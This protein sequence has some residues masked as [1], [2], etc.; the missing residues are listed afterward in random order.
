MCIRINRIMSSVIFTCQHLSGPLT[1]WL[2]SFKKA[3]NTRGIKGRSQEGGAVSAQEGDR[4]GQ[5]VK[6]RANG[7]GGLRVRGRGQEEWEEPIGMGGCPKR[8]GVGREGGTEAK[9]EGARV[10]EEG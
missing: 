5:E 4:R 10:P 3:W 8:E 2:S 6:L 9:R 1:S 7:K